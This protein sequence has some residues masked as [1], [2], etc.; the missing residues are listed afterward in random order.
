MTCVFIMCFMYHMYCVD[1]L[2]FFILISLSSA[3]PFYKLLLIPFQKPR[4]LPT[5]SF[6]QT[7]QAFCFYPQFR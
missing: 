1:I 5:R 3:F 2:R 4:L 6:T 7:L